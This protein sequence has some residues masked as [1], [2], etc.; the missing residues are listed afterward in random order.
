MPERADSKADSVIDSRKAIINEAERT[1]N[2]LTQ[3][4]RIHA[5]QIR[6]ARQAA[7]FLV[8]RKHNWV[9]QLNAP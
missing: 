7:A 8:E 2:I 6:L 1:S 3:L 9:I 4:R 5:S